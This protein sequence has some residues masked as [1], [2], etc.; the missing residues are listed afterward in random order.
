MPEKKE[1]YKLEEESLNSARNLKEVG[2]NNKLIARFVH[3][4]FGHTYIAVA[5]NHA[6]FN[7][8]QILSAVNQKKLNLT[9]EQKRDSLNY[10]QIDLAMHGKFIPK[11]IPL[12]KIGK[13]IKRLEGL[14]KN[15]L[16]V[17]P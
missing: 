8:R 1:E 17:L 16:E 3:K 15:R 6:G 4:Q 12:K 11:G 9:N 10:L 13:E 14:G 7:E 2:V 5:L